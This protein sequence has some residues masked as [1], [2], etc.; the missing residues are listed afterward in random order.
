MSLFA[1][2]TQLAV[3]AVGRR[4]EWTT[5][6]SYSG[7]PAVETVGL[8]MQDAVRAHYVVDLRAAA[9]CRTDVLTVATLDLTA[10]YTVTIDGN[11]VAY[12]A[13]ADGAADLADVL[14]GI[15]AALTADGTVGPLMTAVVDADETQI[16]IQSTSE[17]GYTLAISATGTGVLAA[18][19][20]PATCTMRL[21]AMFRDLDGWRKVADAEFELDR[22]GRGDFIDVPGVLRLYVELAEVTAPAGDTVTGITYAP[23]QVA[24]GPCRVET[25]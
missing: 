23:A 5:L 16:T 20:E 1:R 6:D 13:N 17:D 3:L 21:W 8:H 11:A 12:D 24:L 14:A 22:R 2:A 9:H 25:S 19:S 4:P 18:A 7:A 15:A 10:T